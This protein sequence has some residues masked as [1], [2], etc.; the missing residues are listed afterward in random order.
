MKHL[1]PSRSKN[2]I[3]LEG[4]AHPPMTYISRVKLEVHIL[5]GRFPFLPDYWT[6]DV[7]VLTQFSIGF[8]FKMFLDPVLLIN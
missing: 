2:L 8:N 1:W 7:I 4:D 5:K 3:F 6:T